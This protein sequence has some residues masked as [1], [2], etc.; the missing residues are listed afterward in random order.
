MFRYLCVVVLV[1]AEARQMGLVDCLINN[2]GVGAARSLA[3]SDDELIDRVLGTNLRA[4]LRLTREMIPTLNKDAS[5][6][7][8]SSVFGEVGYPT[9]TI[10]AVTKA[11]ISQ[12]TRQLV[13]DLSAHGVRVNAVA[14]GVIRT[15]MTASR[16]DGNE[17]YRKAMVG[18]TP[19]GSVG[20]PDQVAS[21]IAFLC[22]DDASYVA[23]QIIAVDGGWLACRIAT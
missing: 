5:I 1:A 9:S 14:P 23:G 18:G 22:S 8:V 20:T 16:L 17:T 19:L 4:V 13:A 10:Y 7:N 2:A 6:V 12:L 21:V 11:G 3:E 15:A